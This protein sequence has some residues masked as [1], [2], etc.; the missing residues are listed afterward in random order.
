MLMQMPC[1]VISPVKS[2]LVNW[3]PWPV[4][5]ISGRPYRAIASSTASRQKALSIVA[6]SVVMRRRPTQGNSGASTSRSRR[7]PHHSISR[8]RASM[9]R[10][11]AMSASDG[12][13]SV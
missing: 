7:S 10:M 3:L 13:A 9:R 12:G 8:C 6:I 4:L 1:V 2:A 11:S 5:K